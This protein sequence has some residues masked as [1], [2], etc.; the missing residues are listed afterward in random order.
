MIGLYGG[1]FD[2]PH[3]AHLQCINLFWKYFSDAKALYV[4]PNSLSPLKTNKFSSKDDIKN[5]V[6]ILIDESGSEKTFLSEVELQK[7]G[8]SFTIDTILNFK[9]HYPEEEIGFIMGS[10]NLQK[11]P[12]WKDYELILKI[13]KL[14]VVP[15]PGF[16]VSIPKE[17]S[18]WSQKIIYLGTDSDLSFD[19]KSTLIREKE[20]GSEEILTPSVLNYI[21]EKGLY[22]Y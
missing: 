10:D 6:K 9:S 1:S 20:P 15:R 19:I 4:I 14:L 5:M 17:L 11:F 13:V 16:S 7:Q 18:V 22:G 12:L 3:K 21:K 8:K 2:P